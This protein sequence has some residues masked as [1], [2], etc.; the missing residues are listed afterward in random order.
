MTNKYLAPKSSCCQRWRTHL[1]FC[2]YGRE[3]FC[4][5]S[6]SFGTKSNSKTFFLAGLRMG[7]GSLESSRLCQ[8]FST[9]PRRRTRCWNF[10]FSLWICEVQYAS[11]LPCFQSGQH[12]L[13][14]SSSFA[15][16]AKALPT[17]TLWRTSGEHCFFGILCEKRCPLFM[18]LCG[19]WLFS[20]CDEV[21]LGTH[22]V[23]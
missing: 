19:G 20:L 12:R 18:L 4:T 17:R 8:T 15:I 2:W 11:V 22:L 13:R 5:K 9:S 21:S 6:N 14:S 3:N 1:N 16:L 23:P 10:T 7:L